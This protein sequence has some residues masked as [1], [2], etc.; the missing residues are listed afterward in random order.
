MLDLLRKRG[1]EKPAWL[2]PSEFARVIPESQM[3]CLV[4][5]FTAQYM[6]LRYGQRAAAGERMLGLLQEIETHPAR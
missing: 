5:E 3:A 4:G 2:T 1:Y 6:D